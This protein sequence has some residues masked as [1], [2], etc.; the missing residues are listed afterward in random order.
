MQFWSWY[1]IL[2]HLFFTIIKLQIAP[3]SI[4]ADTQQSSGLQFVSTGLPIGLQ[5]MILFH[6]GEGH[7]DIVG[8]FR[9]SHL[10]CR[11]RIGYIGRQFSGD[12]AWYLAVPACLAIVWF[13]IADP[14]QC[15]KCEVPEGN[16]K[17]GNQGD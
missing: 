7:N 5:D 8:R 10:F 15:S 6:D 1:P 3:Q 4:D 17:Q 2:A 11:Y 14:S 12:D 16:R 13:V 9:F